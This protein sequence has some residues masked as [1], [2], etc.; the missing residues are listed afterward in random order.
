V[1]TSYI[2]GMF[3]VFILLGFVVGAISGFLKAFF[4]V[5]EVI[6]TIFLNWIICYLAQWLFTRGNS[7]FFEASDSSSQIDKFFDTIVGT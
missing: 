1:P 5:H 7:I 3:F 2:V 6:S 4:N